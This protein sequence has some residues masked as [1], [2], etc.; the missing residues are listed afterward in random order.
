MFP[1]PSEQRRSPRTLSWRRRSGGSCVLR[2][3]LLSGR[4]LL[5]VHACRFVRQVVPKVTRQ[6]PLMQRGN[7]TRNFSRDHLTYFTSTGASRVRNR[8]PGEA[9]NPRIA[10]SQE[11]RGARP[12][13]QPRTTVRFASPSPF[14]ARVLVDA[15]SADYA[16][17]GR[18]QADYDIFSIE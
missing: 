3:T 16:Q 7:Q 9:E 4:V 13:R 6:S 2:A 14:N 18:A 17:C 12:H 5:W 8:S 1:P 15:G 10:A 11:P